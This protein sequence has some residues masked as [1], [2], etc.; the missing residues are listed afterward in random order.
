MNPEA[1]NPPDD[2]T[3]LERLVVENPDLEQL[4]V[5]LDRFNLFEAIGAVR[6]ELRHSDFLAYLLDP[7]QSHGLGCIFATRL[8]QRALGSSSSAD[9]TLRPVDLA[10][11]NLDDLQVHRE[12]RN[13][14]LLLVDDTNRVVVVIENKIDSAEHSDQLGRYWDIVAAEYPGYRAVGLFLTPDGL[15]PSDE[16]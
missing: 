14:E 3:A 5:L 16:R 1:S 8:L 6:Q 13:I 7:G 12:W 9:L 10:L 4:E 15:E 11:W 2:L